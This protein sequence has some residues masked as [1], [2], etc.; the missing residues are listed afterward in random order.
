[1]IVVVVGPSLSLGGRFGYFVFFSAWGEGKGESGATGTGVG[2]GFG[3]FIEN[4]R[5]GVLEDGVG[6]C[7]GAGRVS[8]GGFGWG[9]G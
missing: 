2:A 1:M 5:R 6:G 7:E 4:L 9:G 8:A 3:F